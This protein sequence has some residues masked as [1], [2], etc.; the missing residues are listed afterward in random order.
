MPHVGSDAFCLACL[1][2][3]LEAGFA[4]KNTVSNLYLGLGHIVGGS[5]MLILLGSKRKCKREDKFSA[6]CIMDS[7]FFVSNDS[8]FLDLPDARD[9]PDGSDAV[10]FC[11][12]GPIKEKQ[13]EAIQ[14]SPSRHSIAV[15]C[16]V[17]PRKGPHSS[18]SEGD[19][20]PTI[21][22]VSGQRKLKAGDAAAP[23]RLRRHGAGVGARARQG[24]PGAPRLLRSLRRRRVLLLVCPGRARRRAQRSHLPFSLWHSAERLRAAVSCTCGAGTPSR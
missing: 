5:V 2:R 4:G 16:R 22:Q 17:G 14:N 1:H 8:D 20:H 21:P 13:M 9:A 18:H 12:N 11:A 7:L 19:I 10:N 3:L 15:R 6:T 23:S 24:A